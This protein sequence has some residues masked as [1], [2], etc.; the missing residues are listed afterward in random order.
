MKLYGLIL[1]PKRVMVMLRVRISG[2]TIV[3]SG[4]LCSNAC[5]S[6]IVVPTA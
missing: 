1:L 2:T 3:M 6:L 4:A 5:T